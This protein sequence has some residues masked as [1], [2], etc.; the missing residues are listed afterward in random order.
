[1][2][3]GTRAKHTSKL[4]VEGHDDRHSVIGLM[5][6]HTHWPEKETEWP[7]FVELGHSAA[8]ILKP[9]Y[10]STRLKEPLVKIIGI[11]L[12]ADDKPGGRYGN[13]RK[14]CLEAFPALPEILPAGGLVADNA[15]GKRLGI[16]IMPDNVSEGCLETFLRY[17]V[18][19]ES[20]PVWMHAIE[21]VTKARTL[22]ASFHDAHIDKA[23]LYTWLAWQ[24]PPS[25]QPGIALTK[26]I[27]D[28]ASPY[29]EPFVAWMKKLYSL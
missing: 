9:A 25:Q 20:A 17:L 27:L 29:A 16:W 10:L 23:N 22:G 11:M 7:L 12:D 6:A 15:D 14:A 5:K 1:M 28:P 2:S 26:K 13:I 24:H 8:E 21:S 3:G 19:N 4:I 18:P